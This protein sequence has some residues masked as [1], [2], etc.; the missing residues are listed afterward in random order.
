MKKFIAFLLVVI[1]IVMSFA[2]CGET[3]PAPAAE[4][5]AGEAPAQEAPSANGDEEE[6]RVIRIAYISKMMTNPWF[7]AQEQG[8]RDEAERLGVEFFSIDA[9]LDDEACQAAWA[10]A[11]AQQIDGLAICITNQ[12]NGPA[13]AMQARERGVALMTLDDEIVDEYGNPVPHVGMPTIE[14]GVLGGEAL[15]ALAHERDFF[16]EGNV[17]RVI[18]IDAPTVT[19]LAPRLYGYRQALLANTPLTEDDF[20]MVETSTAM[21]EESLA[22]TQA[23][24]QAHPD[25]THWIATGVNDDTAVAVILAVE[26]QGR[27][28]MENV[29][30]CGLGGHAMAVEQFR[31]GNNSFIT[32]VLNPYLQG[33]LAMEMLY[34]YVVYDIPMPMETFVNGTIATVDNWMDLITDF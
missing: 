18:Q 6:G 34:N 7:V 16:A 4:T 30:A 14:V 9:N 19:V 31:Q 22:A 1:L 33:V 12:G 15:A 2:A 3:A 13:L 24:I 32:I 26:E 25:V 23:T 11:F 29:L 28:P 10:T 17:V 21:L 20:V 27:I 8:L 5:P